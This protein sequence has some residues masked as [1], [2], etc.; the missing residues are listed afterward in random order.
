MTRATTE[1]AD[2]DTESLAISRKQTATVIHSSEDG[3][4]ENICGAYPMNL[5]AK[6]TATITKR[7]S[8][9]EL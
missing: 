6:C 3:I 4:V 2:G 1:G 8:R 7:P 9:G 5:T